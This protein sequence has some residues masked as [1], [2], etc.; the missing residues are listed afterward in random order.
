[1][2]RA[3]QQSGSVVA[4]RRRVLDPFASVLGTGRG[5]IVEGT[6]DD[7]PQAFT[8]T[9]KDGTLITLYYKDNDEEGG[10]VHREDGPARITVNPDGSR[11]EDW[12]DHGWQH[13]E[14]GPAR[15]LTAADG[16]VIAEHYYREGKRHREDGPA[17]TLHNADGS[18]EETYYVRGQR[19][20]EDGPAFV[21]TNAAGL[22]TEEQFRYHDSLHREGGP[23][24]IVFDASGK[25]IH[26]CNYT[27]GRV[28]WVGNGAPSAI[29]TFLNGARSASYY[30]EGKLHGSPALITR[31]I[32]GERVDERHYRHGELHREDGPAVIVTDANG[33][34]TEAYYF[35]GRLHRPDGPAFVEVGAAD[36]RKE[37]YRHGE[38]R[39]RSLRGRAGFVKAVATSRPTAA[40]TSLALRAPLNPEAL[41]A[42][43]Q[44]SP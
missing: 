1:M 21:H 10:I 13:R 11:S 26:E 9:D 24:H 23:A 34:R 28:T 15:V 44:S 5:R 37:F 8:R 33:V 20:R 40:S 4:N 30:V 35:R 22:I 32:N 3:H 25:I 18:T 17:L 2:G 19:H 6:E 36:I 31:N 41:A 29:T 39:K 43:V 7:R 27:H 16:S 12:H 42:A 14:H 38:A